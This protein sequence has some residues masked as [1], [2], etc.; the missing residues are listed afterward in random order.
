MELLSFE[1]LDFFDDES[2]DDGSGSRYPCM[3]DFPFFS[4]KYVVSVG[5]SVGCVRG[6][7]SGF[8]FLTGIESIGDVVPL[9]VFVPRGVKSKGGR[10]VEFFW[11]SK[12]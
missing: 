11:C 4:G 1:E 6:V 10:L 2:D 5:E 12:Y 8:F 9:V 3:C 7:G